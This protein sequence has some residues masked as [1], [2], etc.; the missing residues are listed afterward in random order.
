M[1]ELKGLAVST[2][3]AIGHATIIKER[4]INIADH[5]ITDSEIEGEIALFTASIDAVNKEIKEYI[6]NF[7][8]SKEDAEII[9]TH[10]MILLDPD[11]HAE[12]NRLITEEKRNVVQAVDMH[13]T[14]TINRFQQLEKEL[15]ADRASDYAD[16]A[17]RL[18]MRLQKI[19][20]T[21]SP[22]IAPNS[23]FVMQDLPPSQVSVLH[24]KKVAGIVL[25]KGTKTSHSVIIARAYGI[26]IVTGVQ[27]SHKIHN[28]DSLILD[29]KK[30]VVFCN[31]TPTTQKHYHDL[32]IKI[33]K[34]NIALSSIKELPT[35]SADAQDIKIFNNI[36]L[37][38]EI[39]TVID[40]KSDGIGLFRTEF[41]YMNRESLP[42]EEEQF[43]EYK[44][45]AQKLAGKPIVIRTID[46]GGDKIGCWY[47]P[48]KEANPYLGCRGIRFSLKNKSI[49]KTQLR[50][51]LRASAFGN[52]RV[53]FPMIATVEEFLDAKGCFNECRKELRTKGIHF[54]E[55]LPVGTMIEI[56]SAA[57]CSGA[58]AKHSDFF[59]IGTNDLLQYT[60]AADRNNP[61]V[62]YAYVPY[63]PAFLHL[64]LTTV[65]SAKKN[66]IP[67]AICG[68]LAADQEFSAFLLNAGVDEFSVGIEHSLSLKKHIRGIDAKKGE[69]YLEELVN[70]QTVRD[71]KEFIRKLNGI[72]HSVPETIIT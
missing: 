36:E 13:F 32:Q 48:I 31:P 39:D 61:T 57:I 60:I 11:F 59:S 26:P 41:F 71:T 64:V 69:V 46:V 5:R 6:H 20:Y 25:S 68:E 45:L 12:I 4:E 28:H 27:F 65:N 58:L 19:D 49:F 37:P 16:V 21:I 55:E 56:P 17:K 34:A 23:I 35:S 22:K 51:I 29:A 70:C 30:G 10:S 3:I 50:A 2:G 52:I 63:N 54:N 66:H 38:H 1:I 72:C 33:N 44:E 14:K 8:L 9:E 15:F 62:A 67:V 47:T 40:L 24:N 18:L 53:M 42:T 7:N 43:I